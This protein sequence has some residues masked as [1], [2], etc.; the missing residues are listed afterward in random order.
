MGGT[1][2]AFGATPVQTVK[3]GLE[4]SGRS[5]E[6]FDWQRD[7]PERDRNREFTRR[8]PARTRRSEA[9]LRGTPIQK[10][11]LADEV[12]ER[13]MEMIESGEV[14]PGDVLPSERELMESLGVGRPAIRE[15]MQALERAGL[16]HIR[17]GERA[18]VA[19]PSMRHMI[20]QMS[21]SMKHLLV[22]SAASLENLKDA[23]LTFELEMARR[24]AERHTPAD[25]AMLTR[26][27]D[28]QEANAGKAAAFRLLDGRF[29]REIAGLSG[30]PIWPALSDALFRWLND[31]HVNLVSVPG[32]ER[33][34]L[35]EHRGII[36][37]IATGDPAAAATAMRDHLNRASDLYRKP[38]GERT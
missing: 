17:H 18:R 26:T 5:G 21:D 23:R 11:K 13:L 31:F 10:R 27:V 9:M 24:A 34:T 25:I 20:D 4:F 35:A 16:V 6:R 14:A 2:T 22:H 19:E 38:E 15:A 3:P 12:R 28:E 29:H 1:G 7:L 32:K 8:G 36:D 30:N 37:A 33:L